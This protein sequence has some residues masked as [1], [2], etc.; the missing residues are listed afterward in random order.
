MDQRDQRGG[1]KEEEIKEKGVREEGSLGVWLG[2]L[3]IELSY[4]TKSELS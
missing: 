2:P 1:I 4:V 3:F